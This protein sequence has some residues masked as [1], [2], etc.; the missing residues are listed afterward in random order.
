MI[1][2]KSSIDSIFEVHD[3]GQLIGR[4][5]RQRGLAGDVPGSD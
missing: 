4:I 5:L 3:D 2:L 1:A